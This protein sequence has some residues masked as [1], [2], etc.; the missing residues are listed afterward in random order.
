MAY[1]NYPDDILL[2]NTKKIQLVF[3]ALLA[4]QDGSYIRSLSNFVDIAGYQDS[5]HGF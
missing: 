1:P 5:R 4:E 2:K 3:I